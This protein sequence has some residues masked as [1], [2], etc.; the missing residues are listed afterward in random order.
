MKTLKV[1]WKGITPLI[2]H[3][4]QCVNPL[5]PIAREMK[6]LNDRPRGYKMTEEELIQ[7]SNLEWESGC[8]WHDEIGVYIP[9][10]NIEATIRNG[11]KASK[12]GKDIEKYVTVADLI[13]HWIMVKN[14]QKKNLLIILSIEI[15]DRWWLAGHVSF[16]QGQDLINGRLHL[17]LHIMKKKL[18]LER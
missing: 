8:Y 15:A 2:M 1:V 13:I 17:I 9:A 10:E 12:K 18:M 11:A 6:K 4:C 14:F 3:S 5:H 7:L 16:V